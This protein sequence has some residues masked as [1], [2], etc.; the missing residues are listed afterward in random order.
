MKLNKSNKTTVVNNPTSFD[1]PAYMSHIERDV[2]GNYHE[3]QTTF[4]THLNDAD[5]IEV[6]ENSSDEVY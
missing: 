3:V 4:T 1:N 2:Q 6:E 5:Y